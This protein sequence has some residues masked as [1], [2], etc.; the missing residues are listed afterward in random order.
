MSVETLQRL[1]GRYADLSSRFRAGWAFHQY[2]ESLRKIFPGE[3]R[4]DLTADFQAAY[5]S[6]KSISARLNAE[7]SGIIESELD[8]VGKTL[9]RL[10]ATLADEDSKLSPQSVRH[11]F[12][13]VKNEDEKVLTQLVKFY[14]YAGSSEAWTE[15]RLD[16]LDF[17]M[18]RVSEERDSASDRYVLIE[19]RRLRE[20]ATGLWSMVGAEDPDEEEIGA[21]VEGL[22][23]LRQAVAATE[24][25]DQLN[26]LRLVDQYREVKHAL[27]A[28]Y[29]YPKILYEILDTNLVFKNLIRQLYVMEE[30]RITADYQR[31]FD[32]EREVPVDSELDRELRSFRQEVEGFEQQLQGEELKL[33]DLAHLRRRIRSLSERLSREGANQE[34]EEA[35]SEVEPPAPTVVIEVG[36]EVVA[37]ALVRLE[38]ALAEADPELPARRAVLASE[39]YSL[40]LEARELE[41]FRRL[42]DPEGG[43]DRELEQTIVEAAALRVA[44]DRLVEEIRAVL[45][46]TAATGEA[47]VFGHARRTL[48]VASGYVA[49]LAAAAETALLEGDPAEAQVLTVLRM[50]LVRDHAGA[51]LL[52]VRPL[53][54]SS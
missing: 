35:E 21:T 50:R 13:R 19:R 23:A 37:E 44:I 24:T 15:D 43:G 4:P 17:L 12:Q 26:E 29:L 10:T 32:L 7:D 22:R 52:A 38:A 27:G 34:G 11:F 6:L 36:D 45:D 33:K 8:G 47:A 20:M 40:R 31:V 30:R 51:W 9:E 28:L 54:T 5:T 41:A 25:L 2:A 53:L 3:P 39:L 49:R 14:A 18:T 46:E 48:H 16:K 42:H 1:H